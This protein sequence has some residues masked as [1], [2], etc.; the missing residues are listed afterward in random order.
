MIELIQYA[1]QL[2]NIAAKSESKRIRFF[3]KKDSDENLKKILEK[4]G[5]Q[6]IAFLDNEVNGID[7]EMLDWNW[8]KKVG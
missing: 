4:C 7:I 6:K 1:T 3:L 5:F 8:E 2:I